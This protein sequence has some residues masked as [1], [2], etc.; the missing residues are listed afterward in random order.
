M[1]RKRLS[2]R[3]RVFVFE[4]AKGVCH[5]CNGKIHVGEPWEV[6]HAVP[7]EMGGADEI[8][9][10]FPAHKKCHRKH[11]SEVDIPMIAK[12]KR[13]EARH[14]GAHRSRRPMPGSKA[15]GLRKRMDGTVERRT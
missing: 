14:I 7:L 8:Q 3:D 5:L 12:A 4:F 2:T 10:M 13:R 6:S 1:T 15:S 11:T 9:N